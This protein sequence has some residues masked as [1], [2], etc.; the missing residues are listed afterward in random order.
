MHVCVRVEKENEREILVGTI[1]SFTRLTNVPQD[2]CEELKIFGLCKVEESP[3]TQQNHCDGLRE[4]REERERREEGRE[5]RGQRR[6]SQESG[7]EER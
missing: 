4:G 1:D 6:W 7:G 2:G 5:P 3:R